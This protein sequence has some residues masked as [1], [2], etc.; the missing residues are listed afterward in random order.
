MAPTQRRAVVSQEP[1]RMRAPSG[2]K[3]TLVT[4]A[5]MAFEG[6]KLRTRLGVPQPRGGVTRAGQDARAIGAEGHACD[7][8]VWP[9]RAKSSAPVLASHSRAVLS[10]EPVRTRGHRG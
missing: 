10:E 4:G 7:K 9:L 2:L 1:V 8:P 3:A 6:E 5:C